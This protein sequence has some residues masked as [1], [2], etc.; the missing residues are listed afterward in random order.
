MYVWGSVE[1]NK[2]CCNLYG[3]GDGDDGLITWQ[4]LFVLNL[5]I[6]NADSYSMP[7]SHFFFRREEREKAANKL[8]SSQLQDS[9]MMI[10]EESSSDEEMVLETSMITKKKKL[11]PKHDIVMRQSASSDNSGSRQQT[12][13]FKSTKTKHLMYP[14]HEEKVFLSKAI[15]K[16]FII[17]V[18]DVWVSFCLS[19][20]EKKMN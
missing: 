17:F 18:R 12:G 9:A 6:P 2:M 11:A 15:N 13:F 1:K 10:D 20:E 4:V 19:G 8:G 14:F 5:T 16:M 3:D 7:G